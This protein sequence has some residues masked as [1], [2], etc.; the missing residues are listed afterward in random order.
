VKSTGH[1]ASVV[2]NIDRLQGLLLLRGLTFST[3]GFSELP[4]E[5][6]VTAQRKTRQTGAPTGCSKT[7]RAR[8]Q[9]DFA[10]KM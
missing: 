5:K 7:F 10:V 2:Q 4:P 8:F 6:V 1:T 9:L 3:E